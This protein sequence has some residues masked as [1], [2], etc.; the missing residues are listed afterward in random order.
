MALAATLAALAFTGFSLAG[1]DAPIGPQIAVVN[2]SHG[3]VS[4]AELAK[5][6]PAFQEYIDHYVGPA[7]NVPAHLVIAHPVP[8]Q[9]Q[10]D[11]RDVAPKSCDCG[12]FH[13]WKQAR[14]VAYIFARDSDLYGGG[15]EIAFTHELAEMLV[16]PQI[17]R[18]ALV[19]PVPVNRASVNTSVLVEVGD[20][21]NPE[22]FTVSGVPVSDFVL[23]SWYQPGA[24]G[25]YDWQ[26]VLIAPV[27]VDPMGGYALEYDN[28][29]WQMLPGSPSLHKFAGKPAH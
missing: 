15:W 6:L 23:P 5:D 2:Q 13:T 9:W 3:Y 26:K 29:A 8:G 11:L 17:N 20:P 4:D 7:W 18:M 25:P 14:P 1:P 22:F 21:V 19:S 12:G 16:D 24:K 27:T 28:G 10:I